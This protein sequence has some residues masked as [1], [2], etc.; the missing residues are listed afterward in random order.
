MRPPLAN[1]S[2]SRLIVLFAILALP[3][4]ALRA[5]SGGSPIRHALYVALGGDPTSGDGYMG[6][7]LA[8]S[9]GLERT[10]VGSRW[11]LRLGADYRRQTASGF[12][13]RRLEDFGVGVSV[14]YGRASGAIRPYLLGGV[15]VADLRTRVRGAR[16]YIDPDG[17]LFPPYSYDHSRW[18]GSVTTGAGTDFTLGRLKLFTEARL[19]MYPARLSDEPKPRRMETTRALYFGVKF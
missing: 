4:T 19:N 7:P 17:V 1:R 9:A 12:G 5:Q 14:R 10:R 16:Y 15:G 3:G 6:I 11:S 2:I 18:N 8:L 13:T